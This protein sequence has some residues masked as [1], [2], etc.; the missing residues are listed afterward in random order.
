MD[1]YDTADDDVERRPHLGILF[2]CCGVYTRAYRR[3][4]QSFYVVRCPKCL[5]TTRVQVG[6]GG[7][8]QRI[9]VAD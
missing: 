5:R 4:D 6:S 8:N 7:T 1:T 3:P 2:R 9:F